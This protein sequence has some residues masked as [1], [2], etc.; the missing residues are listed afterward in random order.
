MRDIAH[1]RGVSYVVDV[2]QMLSSVNRN[3][4][5]KSH[6]EVVQ[7][8]LPEIQEFVRHNHIDV[9][10]EIERYRSLDLMPLKYGH[11]AKG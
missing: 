11:Q 10:Y 9:L 5:Y 4:N 3:V 8:F 6:P 7:P 2:V 1:G